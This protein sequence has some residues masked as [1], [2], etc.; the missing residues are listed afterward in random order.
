MTGHKFAV[1]SYGFCA[2][3]HGTAANASN[4]VVFVSQVITPQIEAVHASLNLWALTKAPLA[5]TAKYGTR[6]WEYTEAGLAISGR[7]GA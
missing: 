3:C 4:L 6:A 7:P 5:L 2:D 1:D